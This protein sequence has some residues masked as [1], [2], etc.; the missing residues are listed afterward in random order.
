[1]NKKDFKNNKYENNKDYF[2]S[3]NGNNTNKLEYKEQIYKNN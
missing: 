1:M 2:K 3:K